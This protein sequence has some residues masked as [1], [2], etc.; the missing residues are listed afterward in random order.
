MIYIIGHSHAINPV[1]ALSAAGTGIDHANWISD[2]AGKGF[3]PMELRPQFGIQD[4]AQYIILNPAKSMTA[5]FGAAIPG[6]PRQISLSRPYHTLLQS[7][8]NAPTTRIF[9]FLQGN[10]AATLSLIENR[11]PLDFMRSGDKIPASPE[12]QIVS[13][14]LIQKHMLVMCMEATAMAEAL[15]AML[16][17][18][19]II[20]P[21]PPPPIPSAEQIMANP[22]AFGDMLKDCNITQASVRMKY[23]QEYMSLM[24]SV[25][26]QLTLGFMVPPGQALTEDGFLAEG[27]WLGATHGN[28]RYGELVAAQIAELSR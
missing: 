11:P 17:Q 21:A 16:P 18:A 13:R 7:M 24:H 2:G 4:K 15:R 1:Q 20:M 25:C 8:E 28:M 22:E 26:E 6:Q 23:Y 5:S 9:A 12:H 10:E 27:Y 19:I 14:A 3:T